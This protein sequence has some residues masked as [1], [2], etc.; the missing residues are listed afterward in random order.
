MKSGDSTNK[1]DVLADQEH[2]AL[3]LKKQRQD[4]RNANSN[5]TQSSSGQPTIKK[6]Q[7]F[8]GR[9]KRGCIVA[10]VVTSALILM[11]FTLAL[12]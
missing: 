4:I 8:M 9:L 6:A 11:F 5:G 10:I 2:W 3:R 12:F 7:T 1:K